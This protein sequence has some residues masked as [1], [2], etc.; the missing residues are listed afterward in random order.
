MEN[1]GFLGSFFVKNLVFW[2]FFLPECGCVIFKNAK[3]GKWFRGVRKNLTNLCEG[4]ENTAGLH[5][6]LLFGRS[7]RKPDN[8]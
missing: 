4:L 2:L 1:L 5:D 7:R 6:T 8:K 3:F